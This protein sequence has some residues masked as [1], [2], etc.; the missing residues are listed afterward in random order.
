M[1][2]RHAKLL[3]DVAGHTARRCVGLLRRAAG[4]ALSQRFDGG[5]RAWAASSRRCPARPSR[6][7][8]GQPS[9]PIDAQLM[10]S[11][12][13]PPAPAPLCYYF[14]GINFMQM[15]LAPGSRATPSTNNIAL[16]LKLLLHVVS[17]DGRAR[18]GEAHVPRTFRGAGGADGDGGLS[19]HGARLSGLSS[20]LGRHCDALRRRDAPHAP[21][22]RRRPRDRPADR[23]D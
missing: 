6:L 16:K 19:G 13:P 14:S 10:V 15:P 5:G 23:P 9:G 20:Y 18:Q 17:R 21:R 4:A 22:A 2:C 1:C 8:P 12:L 11:L 3:L 7:Q